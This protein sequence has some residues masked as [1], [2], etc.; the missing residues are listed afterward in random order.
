MYVCP[1]YP[2]EQSPGFI[3]NPQYYML[4][5]VTL[6]RSRAFRNA[7]AQKER[8]WQVIAKMSM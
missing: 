6:P 5:K 1:D 7:G 8:H 4:G 3:Y 2:V